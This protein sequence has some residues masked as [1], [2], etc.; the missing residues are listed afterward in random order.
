MRHKL[1]L[2]KIMSMMSAGDTYIHSVSMCDVITSHN[3]TDPNKK[4]E[5]GM[6]IYPLFR[7]YSR[8]ST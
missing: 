5:I 6:Y 4:K 8:S 2:L 7:S 3:E 1:R